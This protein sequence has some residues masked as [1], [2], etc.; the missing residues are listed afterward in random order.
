MSLRVGENGLV[1]YLAGVG[2]TD[3][4]EVVL[5]LSL[6]A[7][8]NG[9]IHTANILPRSAMRAIPMARLTMFT[10]N[11]DDPIDPTSVWGLPE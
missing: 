10:D 8:E 4:G 5:V 11:H 2:R 7:D 6:L 1:E 3:D 9:N